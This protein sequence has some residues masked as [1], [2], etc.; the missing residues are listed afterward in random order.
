M[1]KPKQGGAPASDTTTN[2]ESVSQSPE[3]GAAKVA[4]DAAAPEENPKAGEAPPSIEAISDLIEEAAKKYAPTPEQIDQMVDT[5]VEKIDF[6]PLIAKAMESAEPTSEALR[7]LVDALVKE[8]DPAKLVDVAIEEREERQAAA[9]RDAEDA[10]LEAQLAQQKAV[11]AETTKAERQ[12]VDA[13]AAAAKRR[14]RV[15]DRAQ[16]EYAK[17]VLSPIASTLKIADANSIELRFGNGQTFL[18]DYA[19]T[20]IDPSEVAYEDDRPVLA[21]DVEPTRD[22][23]PFE[24]SEVLLLVEGDGPVSVWRC[25]LFPPA[26]LGGGLQSRFPANSLM[27]RQVGT[28]A[29]AEAEGAA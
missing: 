24:A 4:A 28:S 8:I 19:L 29:A 3:N 21:I 14:Q 10:E 16:R 2:S 6:L 20:D 7:K 9:K 26:R 5:A 13:E 1:N 23:V 22:L 27:F 25:E 12:A 15:A 17:L 18:P 11:R